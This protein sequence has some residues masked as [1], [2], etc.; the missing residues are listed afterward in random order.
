MEQTLS[1]FPQTHT[2]LFFSF[3]FYPPSHTRATEELR[4]FIAALVAH[5]LPSGLHPQRPRL[6]HNSKKKKKKL[7]PAL[8]LFTWFSVPVLYLAAVR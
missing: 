1:K 8:S 4:S 2:S 6:I 7:R 3:F 5:T